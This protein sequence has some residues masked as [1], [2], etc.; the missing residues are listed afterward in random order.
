MPTS[1]ESDLRADA[2]RALSTVS[3]PELDEPVTELG[4]VAELSV[5]SAGAVRVRLRLPTYFCAPNFAYLMVTDAYDAV[6][7]VDGVESVEVRLDD[8]F[9]SEEINAGIAAKR[10]FAD[11]FSGL[12]DDELHQLRHEFWRKAHL[13]AQDR[14]CR[15]LA[16]TGY[17]AEDLAGLRLCDVEPGEE[18][19]RLLRR[20]SDLGLPTAPDQPLLVAEDGRPLGAE[21]LPAHLRFAQAVR[22]SIDSNASFCRGLL[23]TRY[24]DD[25]TAT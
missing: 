16:S 12:A 24:G 6:A 10:G 19:D 23:R 22:V 25:D 5:D 4:F 1:T 17:A 15:T 21:E 9:A 8:H 7:A 13:A 2:W 20:R 3:D 18:L 11:T 14:V